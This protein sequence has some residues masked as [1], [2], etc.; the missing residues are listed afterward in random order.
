MGVV[1]FDGFDNVE[2]E[3]IEELVIEIE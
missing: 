3:V 1:C 2:F